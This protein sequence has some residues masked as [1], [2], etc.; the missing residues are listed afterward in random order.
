MQRFFKC[1]CTGEAVAMDIEVS[2]D[3]CDYGIDLAFWRLGHGGRRMGWRE[4]ARRIWRLLRGHTPYSDMVVLHPVTARSLGA[5]LIE[6]AHRVENET[7][8]EGKTPA[9]E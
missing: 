7:R 6:E 1:E 2:A 9:P 8:D 3:K 5:A 4:R